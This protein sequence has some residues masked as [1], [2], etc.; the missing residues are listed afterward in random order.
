MIFEDKYAKTHISKVTSSSPKSNHF[1]QQVMSPEQPLL[2]GLE[3]LLGTVF[4]SNLEKQP[5]SLPP[6]HVSFLT[7]NGITQLRHPP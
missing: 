7:K 5:V 3:F 2:Q 6:S 4:R 1:G